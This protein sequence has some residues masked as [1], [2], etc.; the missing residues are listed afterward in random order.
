MKHL[1]E[2]EVAARLEGCAQTQ[3]REVGGFGRI[4]HIAIFGGQGGIHILDVEL[5]AAAQGQAVVILQ[6]HHR[7]ALG[8]FAGGTEGWCPS[9][10]GGG[11]GI[12]RALFEQAEAEFV[13]QQTPGA[14]VYARLAHPP[15]AHQLHN[16][17]GAGFPAELVDAGCQRLDDA[18]GHAQ[19]LDP[20][21]PRREGRAHDGVIGEHAPVGA[22]DAVEA[23][24]FAQQITDDALV[25]SEAHLFVFCAHGLGIVGHHHGCARLDGR[26]EGRQVIIEVA[27]WI[28]LLRAIGKVRVAA[29]F[30]RSATGK[31]LGCAGDA[32][33]SQLVALEAADIGGGQAGC[34]QRVFTEG[35]VDA[36]P[37]R[38]G[39]EVDHR[40][41]GGAQADGEIFLAG[42]IGELLHQ[43]R[44]ADG[45]QT[46][47][48]GPLRKTGRADHGAHLLVEGVARVA[49][50]GDGDAQPRFCRQPLQLVQPLSRLDRR[51][52]T[53]QV[54]MHQLLVQQLAR[55]GE[56][57]RTAVV[58]VEA[59]IGRDHQ[60]GLEHQAGSFFQRHARKQVFHPLVDRA[61]GVLIGQESGHE[62]VSFSLR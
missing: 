53:N 52:R 6:Q 33:R 57:E 4:D 5:G 39:G 8:A 40:V 10:I 17:L 20:P 12:D 48:L 38:L 19:M 41:Q 23:H 50:H 44:V 29:V 3:N 54:E 45:P 22:D 47:R 15:I 49:G 59:A 31:V 32:L 7:A 26:G 30:L 60:H 14:F 28:G 46:C 55:R 34:Q 36:P 56:A 27:A 42:D 2:E 13:A 9:D 24:L 18:L 37:A 1:L 62:F 11:V 43:L 58:G 16:Q 51:R 21:S 25:E 61:G 35:A